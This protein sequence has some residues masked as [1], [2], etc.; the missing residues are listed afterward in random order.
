MFRGRALLLADGGVAAARRPALLAATA[1]VA[2]SAPLVVGSIRDPLLTLG[3]V[4]GIA[5]FAVSVV[6]VDLALLLLLGTIP[7]EAAFAPFASVLSVT[8]VAGI[9]CFASFVVNCLVTRRKFRVEAMHGYVF[10]LLGIA[11]LSSVQAGNVADALTVTARYASFA[12]LFLIVSQLGTEPLV[13]RRIVWTLSVSGAASSILA[14]DRY[15]DGVYFAGLLYSSPGEYAFVLVG[16]IPLTIWLAATA[17]WLLR[18]PALVLAA[19]MTTAVVFTFSRGALLGLA[20]AGVYAAIVHVR[21]LPVIL[22][23]LGVGAAVVVGV[24]KQNPEQ[25]ETSFASKGNVAD[26]NVE[27]RKDTWAAALELTAEHPLLGVGPGNFKDYLPDKADRPAGIGE[28]SQ[29]HNSYLDVATEVGLVG[30]A[31]FLLYL[32][33]AFSRARMATAQGLGAPGLGFAV[34]VAL[35]AALVT[36]FFLSGQ[37]AATFWVLGALAVALCNTPASSRPGDGP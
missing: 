29:V 20:A 34:T 31:A 26:T 16:I 30:A 13:Q 32:A 22:A 1:A 19:L 6:R 7:L 5:A 17:T 35:V 11:L 15:L 18:I 36:G 21:R 23:I 4:A 2:V 37:Y 24:Y 33:T 3:I 9:L 27:S 25:F 14:V 12:L 28:I 10:V 8:K